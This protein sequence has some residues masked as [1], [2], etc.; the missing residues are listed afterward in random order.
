MP[1]LLT[2]P[3]EIRDIVYEYIFALVDPPT[4]RSPVTSGRPRK[5]IHGDSSDPN[6]EFGERCNQYPL[7][8]L[9]I[10]STSLLL[11]NRQLKAEVTFFMQS[12]E[13]THALVY[14]LDCLIL[15]EQ[16]LYPTWLSIPYLSESIASVQVTFRVEGKCSP[17]RRSAWR[18]GDGGPSYL[19]VGYLVWSLFALL[20]R[21]LIR[22]PHFLGPC[23]STSNRKLCVREILLNVVMP[24]IPSH[25][26]GWAEEEIVALHI[27][28]HLG[29]LLG[30]S[31]YTAGYRDIVYEH[32]GLIRVLLDG[33]ELRAW[34]LKGDCEGTVTTP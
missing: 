12:L 7:M 18:A 6:V 32:V 11:T 16:Y 5:Q 34:N 17:A 25:K 31:K 3:Q 8:P 13:K 29:Y 28:S 15:H 10:S 20:R 19:G 30:N 23:L 14:Q 1:H 24:E 2:L 4:E 26:D 22:G 33:K 21:F 27:S 9:P